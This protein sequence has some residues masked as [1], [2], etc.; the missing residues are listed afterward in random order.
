[1]NRLTTVSILTSLSILTA[2]LLYCD[3]PSDDASLRSDGADMSL[4]FGGSACNQCLTAECAPELAACEEDPQCAAYWL[5]VKSCPLD[6]QINARGD[7]TAECEQRCTQTHPPQTAFAKE[8]LAKL[9]RCHF[10][11]R[12][13]GCAACGR[14]PQASAV[15]PDL[16]RQQCPTVSSADMAC[17]R[18]ADTRCCDSKQD[19]EK[20][21]EAV[22]LKNCMSDCLTVDGMPA[23]IGLCRSRCRADHP[24]G[25]VELPP[26]L[27]CLSLT[28][29]EAC[30][31]SAA[32]DPCIKCNRKYCAKETVDCMAQP[33]CWALTQCYGDC[34]YQQLGPNS[35][36][37]TNCTMNAT[38][39]ARALS[40]SQY[41]C[42][43]EECFAECGAS[44]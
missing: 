30:G 39:A 42:I 25:I 36:C 11:G 14:P 43:A 21:P 19:Y 15:I 23:N 35:P 9:N 17:D 1:M 8:A 10:A 18:C 4:Q 24:K 6:D 41:F 20:N 34:E 44:L 26:L 16:L 37:Y 7:A 38:P 40:A 31:S 32:K 29:A 3:A 5:C 2:L 27:T 22:A 12:G 28:C 13:T 33:D